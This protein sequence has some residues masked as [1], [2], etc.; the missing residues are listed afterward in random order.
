MIK[1]AAWETAVPAP[2]TP[3]ARHA[4]DIAGQ[5]GDW[6]RAELKTVSG[7]LV[8]EARTDNTLTYV[9]PSANGG[10]KDRDYDHRGG[11]SYLDADGDLVFDADGRSAREYA[12][13]TTLVSAETG[14]AH[15]DAAN[16][17]GSP[18]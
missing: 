16:L 12:N 4:R 18:L 13:P 5:K 1:L 14:S 17:E 7:N 10:R 15:D 6:S 8:W 3:A 9:G 11:D 2:E